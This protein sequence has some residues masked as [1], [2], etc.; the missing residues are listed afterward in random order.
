MNTSRAET[1]QSDRG[2][3]RLYFTRLIHNNNDDTPSLFSSWQELK[4]KSS[5]CEESLAGLT[6]IIKGW[7]G[8][9][10]HSYLFIT[11]THQYSDLVP[12]C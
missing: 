8:C 3:M 5:G 10:K 2:Q 11:H 12:E 4:H 9:Q 1:G 7:T 6:G